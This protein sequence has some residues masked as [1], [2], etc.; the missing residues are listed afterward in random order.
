VNR[1]ADFLRDE[2]RQD[3]NKGMVR[4]ED[5]RWVL[6]PRHREVH[7]HPE[8]TDHHHLQQLGLAAN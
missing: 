7:D 8:D 4:A 1:A 5:G 6:P 2:W 3:E